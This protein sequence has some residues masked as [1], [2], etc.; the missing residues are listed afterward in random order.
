MVFKE[1]PKWITLADGARMIVQDANEEALRLCTVHELPGKTE[2]LAE[3]TA[4][5]EAMDADREELVAEA[6]KRGIKIDGRW[7]TGRI[8]EVLNGHDAA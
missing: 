7:N 2:T 5:E 3:E 8:R 4:R 1:Y 6:K